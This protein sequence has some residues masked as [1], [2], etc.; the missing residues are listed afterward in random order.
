MR[1]KA[2][3]LGLA[4]LLAADARDL[5]PGRDSPAGDHPAEVDL[6]AGRR[7]V[8][9]GTAVSWARQSA[10]DSSHASFRAYL[11][12]VFTYAGSASLSGE[13][14]KVADASVVLPGDVFLQGGFPGHAVLVAD[15]VEDAHG[16][17]EFLLPQS[18]TPAQD[19]HVLRNPPH[20]ESPWFPALRLCPLA[21]PEWTFA[22][23]DLHRFAESDCQARDP[24]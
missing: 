23:S 9:S 16:Q 21:T 18:Y 8:V 11:D 10:P 1:W 15:V 13:L 14:E 3:A 17:R 6:R 22:Y 20:A 4:T 19:I 2:G 5:H 7:P 12:P 24:R